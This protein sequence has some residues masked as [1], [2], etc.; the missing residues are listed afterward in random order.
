MF[1]TFKTEYEEKDGVAQQSLRITAT[2]DWSTV[3]QKRE[4]HI[5]F[6]DIAGGEVAL[7]VNGEAVEAE[8]VLT[9]CA[10]IDLTVEEGK[11]Y[12][13]QVRYKAKTRTETLIEHARKVLLRAEGETVKKE[14]LYQRLVKVKSE[15]EYAEIIEESELVSKTAKACLKEVL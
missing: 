10:A 6:K 2:G 13:V 7:Y 8:E 1:T 14:E 11:E 3:P 15:R 12:C 9:D 5:R 4:F